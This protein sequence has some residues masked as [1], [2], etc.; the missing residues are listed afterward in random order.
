MKTGKSAYMISF[1][2]LKVS[3]YDQQ[4]PH[5]QTSDQPT[6]PLGRVKERSQRHDIQNNKS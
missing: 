6:A 4:M 3:E 2:Y 1:F 5:S